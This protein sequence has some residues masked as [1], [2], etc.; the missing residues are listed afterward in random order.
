MPA[1]FREPSANELFPELLEELRRLHKYTHTHKQKHTH[2]NKNI[3]TQT[4][5]YTHKQKHTHTNTQAALTHKH[6]DCIGVWLCIH[7]YKHTHTH[8]RSM[9]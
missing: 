5:T 6:G 2:T 3:H 4:K 8:T 1:G 7:T 9:L